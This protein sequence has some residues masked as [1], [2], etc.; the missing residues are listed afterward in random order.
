MDVVVILRSVKIT[1]L[2]KLQIPSRL[3]ILKFNL[4]KF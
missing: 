1:S 2:I 4:V 3:G